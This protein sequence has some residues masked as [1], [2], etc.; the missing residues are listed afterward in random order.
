MNIGTVNQVPV[1]NP[2]TDA[3]GGF[4]ATVTVPALN[5]GSYTV[6]VTAPAGSTFTGTAQITITSATAA[7]SAVIPATAFQ[8]LTSNGILTLASAAPPGGTSFGA[9]VPDLPGDTL[10]EVEPF[11]VLILTLSADA[12]ISVSG[13]PGVA[14]TADTPTFF[15]VGATVT[16]EVVS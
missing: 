14:V 6:T 15:A 4:T 7:G 5:P 3:T 9:F 12:T 2:V 16:I 10:T 11:G 13:N 1:P 8:A